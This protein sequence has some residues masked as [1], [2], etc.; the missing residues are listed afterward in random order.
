MS[1]PAY[2]SMS[3]CLAFVFI[4]AA[5]GVAAACVA[6]IGPGPL[7]AQE[8][9]PVA[10]KPK[11][12]YLGLL[13]EVQQLRDEVQRLNAEIQRLNAKL[14]SLSAKADRLAKEVLTRA[15]ADVPPEQVDVPAQ[16]SVGDKYSHLLRRIAVPEDQASYGKFYDWGYWSGTSWHGYADLPPGYW[17]YVFPHW[18]IWR[19]CRGEPQPTAPK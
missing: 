14:A 8:P 10:Q 13:R 12:E 6:A 11:D 15:E 3:K 2:R 4:L 5:L 17:V 9:R 18:Y 7:A 16:A 1:V 19:D